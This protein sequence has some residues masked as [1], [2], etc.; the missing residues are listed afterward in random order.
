MNLPNK[1]W[2]DDD[3]LAK[4]FETLYY[5]LKKEY[6]MSLEG[7]I[8]WQLLKNISDTLDSYRIKALIDAKT[9]ILEA[10]IYSEEQYES[11]FFQMYDREQ[12]KYAL[13]NFLKA[14]E[15]TNFQ[16]L[17]EYSKN[18]NR[19]LLEVLV[20]LSL[21]EKEH[22]VKVE[23]TYE[24]TKVAE[25]S[26]SSRE[27]KDM[28]IT[29]LNG[30]RIKPIY[31]PVKTIFE[32]KV[33]SGC[34]LCAGICPVN[35]LK[36]NNGFGYIDE[37][38]CIRCGL[39]YY[40][41]PR[42]F[43]PIDLLNMSQSSTDTFQNYSNVGYYLEIYS[44]KTKIPQIAD[45]CQ[46]GGVSSTCLYHLFDRGIINIAFGAKMSN[47]PW[48]P[49]TTV[50]QSKDDIVATAGTKYV[51][52]ANLRELYQLNNSDSAIAIVGVPCQMQALTKA[53]LYNIGFPF[54]SQ[55]KYKIGIFCMES[56]SYPSVLKICE[57]LNVDVKDVKK[58]NINKGKFFVYDNQGEE[59]SIP[60]KEISHLARED[61][62]LCFDLTSEAADLS[63]GSIGSPSGWNTVIIRTPKGKELFEEL[64]E[65]DLIET[66]PISEVKPG[67]PL[68]LKVAGSKR[69][70]CK[71]HIESK[72]REQKRYPD[73][74]F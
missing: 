67:L 73:Y 4:V 1:I 54:L 52:N 62:E 9:E 19:S 20:Q 55:L 27:F 28:I 18:S 10:E 35:C 68:L 36:L 8:S 63:V 42:T 29:P 72:Q 41:C 32:S 6:N 3:D 23:K 31:E 15:R 45:V 5:Q 21:L 11:I 25:E 49:E 16:K 30:S 46:D 24:D 14:H 60:I 48:R 2:L 51:N 22:L 57:Q 39:C 40:S 50:L 71:K 65:R 26:P 44:A 17:S 33:C 37:E 56:F 53:E 64:I 38:K 7:N 74:S 12:E 13:L 43:L 34:G 61:C 59:F 70:K 66:K 69:T 58:M 47:T